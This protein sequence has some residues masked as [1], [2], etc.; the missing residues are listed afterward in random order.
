MM[1]EGRPGDGAAILSDDDRVPRE[2]DLYRKLLDLST[3]DEVEPFLAEALALVVGLAGARRAYIEIRDDR[4]RDAAPFWMAHGCSDDEIAAVQAGFS[5]G[6]IAHALASGQT[7][8]TSSAVDDP[9]F[10]ERGSVRA[11]RLKAVLCAP[12]GA[13]PPL[14]VVYLQDRDQPGPFRD[15][16]RAHVEMFARHLAPFADRLLLRRRSAASSD[17]TSPLR[18]RLRVES[19][20]GKSSAIARLLQAISSVAPLDVSVLLTGPTGSGKTAVA[21]VLHENSPRSGKPFIEIN[22]GALPDTLFESELFGALPGAHSTAGRRI[23]GKVEAAEGGTLFL[24]EV[25]ELSATAQVKLLQLLQSKEYFPLGAPRA[26]T[27]DVRIIAAT[28]ADLRA[29]VANRTFREDLFYRLQ[30]LPI[31]VPSLAE[32]PADIAELATYLCKQAVRKYNLPHLELSEGALRALE[33]AEWPGNVRQLDNTMMRAAVLAAGEGVTRVE[34]KH[35]FP[36]P[37]PPSLPGAD[38]GDRPSGDYPAAGRPTLQ[39]ATRAFQAGFVRGV[40]EDV[41][42]NITEAAARLDVARSHVYNLI[43]AFGLERRRAV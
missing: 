33:N 7:I 21:R 18:K 16:D 34:Q 42:W 43:R 22:C 40:L 31:R 24:D 9:R 38:S 25:A 13:S 11:N 29:A 30:V 26:S 14:G 37:F 36:E 23:Q 3:R 6:V 8:A 20:A 19:I 1:H 35:L 27:A 15:E 32:R 41:G 10:R 12:I 2:R 17:P 28:N 4:D 5:S 39:A